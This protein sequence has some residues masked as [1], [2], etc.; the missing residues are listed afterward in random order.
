[1]KT[2]LIFLP[3][4]LIIY[5]L[6]IAFLNHLYAYYNYRN[7]RNRKKGLDEIYVNS[8]ITFVSPVLIYLGTKVLTILIDYEYIYLLYTLCLID[9][10]SWL[11]LYSLKQVFQRD[12]ESTK[13]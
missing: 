1:M 9:P 13:E 8:Y 4:L 6:F 11:A 3:I 5:G 7:Y 12:K 2:L 10:S